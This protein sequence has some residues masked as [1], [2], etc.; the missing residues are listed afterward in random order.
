MMGF[1]NEAFL[2]DEFFQMASFLTQ[3]V[4][5]GNNAPIFIAGTKIITPKRLYPNTILAKAGYFLFILS[6]PEARGHCIMWV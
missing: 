2:N 6:R 1:S 3:I 4:H 5:Q